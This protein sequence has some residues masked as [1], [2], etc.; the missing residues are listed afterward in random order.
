[1]VT[2]KGD[3][4][5]RENTFVAPNGNDERGVIVQC[6]NPSDANNPKSTKGVQE[7]LTAKEECEKKY[8]KGFDAFVISNN[9]CSDKN[10]NEFAKN[11][12]VKLIHRIDLLEFI[13]QIKI[14]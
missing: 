14:S 11:N 4:S 9:K 12:S 8:K 10:T 2:T 7:V 1:M 13:S 3:N 6:L 5:N